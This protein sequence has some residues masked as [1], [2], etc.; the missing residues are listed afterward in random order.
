MSDVARAARSVDYLLNSTWHRID[1]KGKDGLGRILRKPRTTSLGGGISVAHQE[2]VID[3]LEDLNADPVIGLRAAAKAAQ[4]GLPLSLD[5]CERLSAILK[6]GGAQLPQPW[7]REARENLVALIG[8][9]SAMIDVFEALD[10]EEIIFSWIPEWNS[11]RSLPQRN[12]LHRHTV[13]RHMVETAVK[14]AA[15][16]R[17]VHR[18]DLLLVGALFHDIGKGTQEDHSERGARLIEPLAK[19]F[20][21]P[22]EDIETLKILVLHHLLLSATATRRDLDDPATIAS[23][24]A[25]IPDLETL[26]L[27][28]A[29]S[30]AD[31]EA[32]GRA[33]WRRRRPRG[34]SRT[35][36]SG[37]L[38]PA[39][40]ML[41]GIE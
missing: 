31:G 38:L 3:E 23:I 26:E 40:V 5:S 2:V 41:K 32:T 6:E 1:F 12:V 17:N 30:I 37:I 29:L 13:D 8:A 34:R 33:A 19:R 15:L 7:P 4:L 28:H 20:G 9:G 21:F 35:A 18:P 39:S 16:T 24:L 14:A 27:L 25:V 36:G 11:V 22:Q 10:Q